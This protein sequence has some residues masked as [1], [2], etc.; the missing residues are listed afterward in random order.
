MIYITVNVDVVG[1]FNED[2]V[3]KIK[4]PEVEFYSINQ[5]VEGEKLQ[6]ILLIFLPRKGKKNKIRKKGW[7]K[8]EVEFVK[9]YIEDGGNAI[10]IFPLEKDYITKFSEF[11]K[12]F[13]FTTVLNN[14]KKLLHVNPNLLIFNRN[15]EGKLTA[16]KRLVETYVHFLTNSKGEV[17]ME[18]NYLPTCMI[19]RFGKGSLVL[20]GLGEELFWKE[21]LKI[22]FEYLTNEY[23]KLF[24]RIDYDI[25]FFKEILKNIPDP[26][27]LKEKYILSIVQ[28]KP[29]SYI[30]DLKDKQFRLEILRL[31]DFNKFE[32]FFHDLTGRK[33]EKSYLELKK[34]LTD[35]KLFDVTEKLELFFIKKISEKRISYKQLIDM[36]EKGLL[37]SEAAN[38][39]VFFAN[40]VSPQDFRNFRES[41]KQ[42]IKW[43][44]KIKIFKEN[45]LKNLLWEKLQEEDE[46]VKIWEE[47][48]KLK[49]LKEEEER[50]RKEKERELLLKKLEREALE[51]KKLEEKKEMEK[52]KERVNV[53][54]IQE[55]LIEERKRKYE[56]A[57]RKRIEKELLREK[58]LIEARKK[59]QK[60][61]KERKKR[62][63]IQMLKRQKELE[64]EVKKLR[65]EKMIA[66]ADAKKKEEEY[67]RLQEEWKLRTKKYK[68][69]EQAERIKA[70]KEL[71]EKKRKKLEKTIAIHTR[72]PLIKKE[73]QVEVK[74][75]PKFPL[76]Y[77]LNDFIDILFN[78]YYYFSELAEVNKLLEEEQKSIE[79][80]EQKIIKEI[81]F[82]F[83]EFIFNP[84][85]YFETLQKLS[86]LESLEE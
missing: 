47:K 74:E 60:L 14:T 51:K 77:E 71:E 70:K 25:D 63:Q 83:I 35:H 81:I 16:A 30:L 84:S 18:G 5:F 64:E 28:N 20:Y 24:K 56:E 73:P 1:L 49:R 4:I 46:K 21:E 32:D 36:F 9:K 33:L 86:E 69:A 3:A 22:W 52:K 68:E 13:N 8:K 37:P 23:T 38:L 66:K 17:I 82:E 40:P 2:I 79:E 7:L 65:A 85:E 75:S 10:I 50:R 41:I 43:N 34:Y 61:Q 80:E 42:I 29:L 31:L 57:H 19:M 78:P 11:G 76:S 53:I 72:E 27:K 26:N 59:R 67:L 12:V 48:Q 58:K 6:D 54:K 15:K 45:E 55:K 39:V 62:R 44:N